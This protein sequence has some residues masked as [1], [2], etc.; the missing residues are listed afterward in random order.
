MSGPYVSP[1]DSF[2]D[3]VL[4][5]DELVVVLEEVLVDDG[6]GPHLGDVLGRRRRAHQHALGLREGGERT[7]V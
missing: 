4:P 7:V 3:L 2:P 5:L 1:F 6:D